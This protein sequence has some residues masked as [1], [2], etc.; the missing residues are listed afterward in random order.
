MMSNRDHIV[1][2]DSSVDNDRSSLS[3][4]LS[5]PDLGA[6]AAGIV[7]GNVSNASTLYNQEVFHARQGHGYA[8]EQAEHL[9][10]L[11][12]G[13]NPALAGVDLAKNGADRIV[14][15]VQ[16]Q[17][18]YCA[19]GSK[20]VAECFDGGKLKY[21]NPDG[22][23]MQIEVPSDMY[24]T[25]IKAMEER[26]KKGEVNGVVDASEAKNIIRKG[27]FTYLQAKNIAKAGTV[28]SVIFDSINGTIIATGAFGISAALSFATSIWDG[29]SVDVATK[30]AAYTGLKVCGTTFVTAVLAGQLTK[31]GLNSALVNSSEAVIK[32]LGPKGSA[33]L[34]NAFRSGNNIY[35]AAAMKNAAKLLRNNVITGVASVAILTSADVVNIFRKRISGKQLFKN[36]AET[37]VSVVGGTAGWGAGATAGAVI[38]SVVPVVGTAI[39][40]TTGALVG[41]FA[42]GSLSG[43]AARAVMGTFVEDDATAMVHIIEEQ[44]KQL[45]CDYL[46][47][48]TE[49][50]KISDNLKGA[51]TGSTL[52]N[53]FASENRECFAVELL[54]PYVE[55]VTF[56][57]KH[58]QLPTAEE[59]QHSLKLVLEEIADTESTQTSETAQEVEVVARPCKKFECEIYV[60]TIAE[61]G[62]HTPFFTN[63]MPQFRFP[64]A[65]VTGTIILPDDVDMCMPGSNVHTTVNLK[66]VLMVTPGDSFVV[67]EGTK[68]NTKIVGSGTV[69]S[70]VE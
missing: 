67:V 64:T 56:E 69:L 61:G 65:E 27:H 11:L 46:L 66:S 35:G 38:G 44:F 3:Q 39:G 68:K 4:N 14:H 23:P 34:A 59:M 15:G 29:E 6:Q 49:A 42:G 57:R 7:H 18:K 48:Q 31:A 26:I 40:A 2:T 41:A 8:A 32:V 12:S 52:K 60:H 37:S 10:D 21:I 55:A 17:T 20:C 22:S 54:I 28:E 47:T 13:K 16:I 43:K 5:K 62:R 33:M 45:A 63:Y 50:E 70:I 24:E 58:I 19:S 25:A 1:A 51:I 53:M 36:L 9:V 30:V